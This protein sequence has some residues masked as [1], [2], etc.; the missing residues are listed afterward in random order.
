MIKPSAIKTND[1]V[2]QHISI[3]YD[4]AVCRETEGHVEKLMKSKKK[5][6]SVDF[7]KYLA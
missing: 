1:T 3:V 5:K 4:Q 6:N 2:S 7:L